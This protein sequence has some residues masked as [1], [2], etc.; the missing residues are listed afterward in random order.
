MIANF[1][2]E[3]LVEQGIAAIPGL[4]TFSSREAGAEVSDAGNMITPPHA[5]IEFTEDVNLDPDVSIVK[6]ISDKEHADLTEVRMQVELFVS[7]IMQQVQTGD[8]ARIKGLGYFKGGL[9]GRL[10]FH[11]LDEENVLPDSFGLPK[12]TASPIIEEESDVDEYR[13]TTPPQ[14]NMPTPSSPGYNDD[15]EDQRNNNLIYWLAVPL[16]FIAALGIYFFFNPSAYDKLMGNDTTDNVALS[17]TTQPSEGA[18]STE[19]LA[20]AGDSTDYTSFGEETTSDESFETTSSETTDEEYSSTATEE[21]EEKP[22]PVVQKARPSVTTDGPIISRTGRY[23]IIVS[24]FTTE[25]NASRAQKQY[26]AKGHQE[27]KIIKYNGK[28]RVSVADF[29][30]QGSANSELSSIEQDFKGAW[31]WKF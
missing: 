27:S 23:Y 11:Q 24:S 30:D 26:K 1:I 8:I 25:A 17:E 31:V 15:E 6:F 19:E 3:A 13:A 18:S 16:I 22:E 4:G 12:I 29:T 10:L 7:S 20:T 21:V 14:Q 28:Y 9:G 5:D 2:K